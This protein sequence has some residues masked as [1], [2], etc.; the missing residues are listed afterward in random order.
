MG[1]LRLPGHD[2]TLLTVV[3]APTQVQKRAFDLLG[4]KPDQNVPIRM[5][6]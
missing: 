3:T 6:G 5:T 1:R 4:V 2:N